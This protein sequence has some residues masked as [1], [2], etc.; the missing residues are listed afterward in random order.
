MLRVPVTCKDN[1]GDLDRRVE[2]TVVTKILVRSYK[3]RWV[4]K[5]MS[6]SRNSQSRQSA[7]KVCWLFPP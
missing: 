7:T 1:R 2:R 4:T 3:L 5:T 6:T